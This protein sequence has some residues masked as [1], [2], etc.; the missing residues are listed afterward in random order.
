MEA[1]GEVGDQEDINNNIIANW[2]I[3]EK[4]YI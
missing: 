1:G 2:G 4:G 3:W